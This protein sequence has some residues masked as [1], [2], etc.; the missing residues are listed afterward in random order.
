MCLPE[1][2]E[3]VLFRTICAANSP[4]PTQS[5]LLEP[6]DEVLEAD[7]TTL[8]VER[9][10][11]V[12]PTQLE[13]KANSSAGSTLSVMNCFR[14]RQFIEVSC[15]VPELVRISPSECYVAPDGGLAEIEVRVLRPVRRDLLAREPVITV[16]MENE[17]ITVPLSFKF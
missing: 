8:P 9:N 13:L 12:Q 11:S 10:W 14:S 4:T 7:T 17:R 6:V 16:S 2:D 3:T 15:S 1:A 5:N